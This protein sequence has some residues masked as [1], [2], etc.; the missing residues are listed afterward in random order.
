M[1]V[2]F[3]ANAVEYPFSS[4]GVWDMSPNYYREVCWLVSSGKSTLEEYL[5]CCETNG[6]SWCWY[7]PTNLL[8]W[9]EDFCEC[10]FFIWIS[11]CFCFFSSKVLKPGWIICSRLLSCSRVLKWECFG[12]T[13][14]SSGS[15][16]LMSSRS[17]SDNTYLGFE[18]SSIIEKLVFSLFGF[19]S[20]PRLFGLTSVSICWSSSS[21]RS[22]LEFWGLR[23]YYMPSSSPTL[24]VDP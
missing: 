17:T 3:L 21:L 19:F 6:L 18:D 2:E 11:S 23:W 4:K 22:S 16:E 20:V 5:F 9:L 7:R 12:S 1:R 13:K 24:K 14:N 15:W 8:F 10:S